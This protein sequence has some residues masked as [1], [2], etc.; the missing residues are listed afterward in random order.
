MNLSGGQKQRLSLAR[1]LLRKP[2]ILILDDCTSALDAR[3][4]SEVL[5]RLR[6]TAGNATVLLISQRISAVMRTDRILCLDNG[7]VQG[8]GSHKELLAVCPTYREIYES[9]IGGGENG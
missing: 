7:R 4:E 3:T 5:N 9:Q 2:R 6:Q 1:A 8:F